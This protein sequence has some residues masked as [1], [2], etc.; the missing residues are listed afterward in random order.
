VFVRD[1][2]E[3]LSFIHLFV[4]SMQIYRLTHTDWYN[5]QLYCMSNLS[6]RQLYIEGLDDLRVLIPVGAGNFSPHHGVQ[7]GSGA[8]PASYPTD[9]RGFFPGSK[10]AGA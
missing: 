3:G 5:P 1:V 6:Y 4:G 7:A 2:C 10:A 8:H 9:K